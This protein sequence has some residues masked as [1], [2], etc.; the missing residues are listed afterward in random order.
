MSSVAAVIYIAIF[1]ASALDAYLEWRQGA[2]AKAHRERPPAEFADRIDPARHRLAQD[3]TLAK[4]RLALAENLFGVVLAFGWLGF[5]LATLC[6]L[7]AQFIAPGLSLQVATVVA[8]AAISHALR[9][10]FDLASA[11]GIEARFGFNRLTPAM[12][13]RDQVKAGGVWL[14]F[15]V[16]VL[17]GFFALLRAYPEH[18]WLAAWAGAMAIMVA[19]LVIYPTFIAPLFN[20]FTPLED[21]SLK[22]RLEALLARCGFESRGLFVMDASTRSTHGNA[23][24]SGLGRAK[25]IVLFDTL[26]Q[27]HSPDEIESILAHELGHFK[28]GHI[29]QRMALTAGLAF[30]G[31]AAMRWA[32]SANGLA[33]AF[34]LR[35]NPG[36]TLVIILFASGPILRLVS[37]LTS[38]LSR[39]AE[40]QAD[41]FAKAMVGKGP[42]IA[43]LSRLARDNLSTLTPDRLYAL[44]N[45]SHP[46]VPARIA[47]LEQ[48]T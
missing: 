1:A 11:F 38:F 13:V 10:P 44:F 3:Y 23:Y 31:F 33:E 9:L 28:L 45:Y 14:L 40:Y 29:A 24:F 7:L 32:F 22:K 18:W 20:A 17:Y 27:T 25:R 41:G 46:P 21:A 39:R 5:G 34:H 2:A 48:E 12:F 8:F 19:M 16:P 47:R 36:V 4:A 6:A 26:L 35:G 30:A 15:T 42:M 43:A 37:P